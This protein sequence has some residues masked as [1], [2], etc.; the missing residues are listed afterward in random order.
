MKRLLLLALLISPIAAQEG[1]EPGKPAPP[2]PAK[3]E[4]VLYRVELGSGSLL[5]GRI[6]PRQWKVLTKFGTLAVPIERIKNV[7]FGRIDG[8]TSPD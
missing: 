6:E 1:T 2:P 4:E 3:E 8:R 7:R 5:V